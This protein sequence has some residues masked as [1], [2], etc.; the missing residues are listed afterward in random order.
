MNAVS[1]I[2]VCFGGVSLVVSFILFI[3]TLSRDNKETIE[4]QA[5]RND[6]INA[7]LL[8]LNLMSKNINQN[9]ADIKVD[10]KAL[11]TD[12]NEVEK[13]VSVI[14]N[15]QQTMWKRIDEFKGRLS[16]E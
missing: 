14:E 4:A 15:E 16:N 2:S 12:M 8:E 13:R 3:R 9:V 1:I 5:N 7:S 10:I 6:K 11:S